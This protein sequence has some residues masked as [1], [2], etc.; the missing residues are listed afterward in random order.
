MPFAQTLPAWI[1]TVLLVVGGLAFYV[2]LGWL[3]LVAF[4]WFRRRAENSIRKAFDGS[5]VSDQKSNERVQVV[6]HTYYG[7]LIFV[8]QDEYRFW[9]APEQARLILW[10]LHM[11]NCTWGLFAR[12]I[13]IIPVL[14]YGNYRAQLRSISKQ[15]VMPEI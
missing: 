10:R 9:A 5:D 6:F 11:F 4:R 12:G 8:V 2:A 3:I 15:S 14:S 7:I 13:L 1:S